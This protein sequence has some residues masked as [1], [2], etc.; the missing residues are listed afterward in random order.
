MCRG[1]KGMICHYMRYENVL[2]ILNVPQH[3][4]TFDEYYKRFYG[5]AS[6]VLD[7]TLVFSHLNLWSPAIFLMYLVVSKLVSNILPRFNSKIQEIAPTQVCLQIS[8]CHSVV[9][10]ESWS[11]LSLLHCAFVGTLYLSITLDFLFMSIATVGKTVLNKT[12]SELLTADNFP[13]HARQ[14]YKKD[15]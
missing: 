15:N 11:T 14:I 13:K 9:L 8:S 3:S 6:M 1:G 7:H 2:N 10:N 5:I 12:L 4:S